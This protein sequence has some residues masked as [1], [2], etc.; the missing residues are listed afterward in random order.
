[1]FEKSGFTNEVGSALTLSPNVDGLLERVGL[2][3]DKNGGTREEWLT[4]FTEK[5]NLVTEVGIGRL[6]K[7]FSLNEAGTI[8]RIDLHEGLRNLDLSLGVKMHLQNAAVSIDAEAGSV[9]LEDGTTVTGD[10]VIGA[11]GIHS[12]VRRSMFGEDKECH[13]FG[14]TTLRLLIPSSDIANDSLARKFIEKDGLL[15]VWADKG[16][17]SFGKYQDT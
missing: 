8:H 5:G 12:R 9:V 17:R 3:T 6:R 2:Y 4:R 7:F 16:G 13:P 10:G 1:M 11:D 15:T 14:V